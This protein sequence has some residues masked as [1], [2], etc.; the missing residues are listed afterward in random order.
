MQGT[1][2]VVLP[3]S[4]LNEL[5]LFDCYCSGLSAEGSAQVLALW[6]GQDLQLQVRGWFMLCLAASVFWVQGW[7]EDLTRDNQQTLWVESGKLSVQENR[8]GSNDPGRSCCCPRY[9][10]EHTILLG[11]RVPELMPGALPW[12]YL[13]PLGIQTKHCLEIRAYLNVF[14]LEQ[15]DSWLLLIIRTD[16]LQDFSS[17]SYQKWWFVMRRFTDLQLWLFH[18]RF[19]P[20]N[21]WNT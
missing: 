6:K 18:P 3:N 20:W 16:L 8:S 9:A 14:F 21:I 5:T 13:C 12:V 10:T 1:R 19:F 7:E 15:E 2:D 4:G 17:N 11:V